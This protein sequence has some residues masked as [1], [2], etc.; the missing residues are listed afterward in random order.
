MMRLDVRVSFQN[1]KVNNLVRKQQFNELDFLSYI[2]GLLGLFA[3]FSVLS[4]VELVYW[5]LIRICLDKI[6]RVSSK[7]VPLIRVP[8]LRSSRL[9]NFGKQVKNYLQESSIHGLSYISDGKF[10][11]R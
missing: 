8:T 11:Q 2:G 6:R 9:D 7:V 4:F 5:F 3:G 10:I 1:D